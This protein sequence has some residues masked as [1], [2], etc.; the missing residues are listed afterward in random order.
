MLPRHIEPV[1]ALTVIWKPISSGSGRAAT[2]DDHK[3]PPLQ[4]FWASRIRVSEQAQD[5]KG[6]NKNIHFE[7]L[8]EIFRRRAAREFSRWS[9]MTPEELF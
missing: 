6:D 1:M 7:T 2:W 5:K 9:G 3:F 8:H 4:N